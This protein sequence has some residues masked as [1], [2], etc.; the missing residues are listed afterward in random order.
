MNLVEQVRL[1]RQRQGISLR[2]LSKQIG[3]AFSTLAR[4]ERG[5]GDYAP[6]T[7]RCLREWLGEDVSTVLSA[8]EIAKAEELGRVIARSATAEILRI[9]RESI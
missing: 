9:I 5:E 6:E 1:E 4:V 8:A 7:E 3:I 2:A